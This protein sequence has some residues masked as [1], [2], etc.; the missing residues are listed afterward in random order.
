M[1][2]SR[3][4]LSW[5]GATVVLLVIGTGCGHSARHAATSIGSTT[6]RP[7]TNLP[8]TA[9]TL[10]PPTLTTPVTTGVPPTT[11][12]PTP[13][14]QATTLPP[15]TSSLPPTSPVPTSV[16]ETATWCLGRTLDAA[17]G[18]TA[19]FAGNG[20]RVVV[21]LHET[22]ASPCLV[23]ASVEVRLTNAQGATEAEALSTP[24]QSSRLTISPS[25]DA[26]LSMTWVRQGC[27]SPTV[28]A[29]AGY[30]VWSSPNGAVD[31]NIT[32]I[33]ADAVAPCHGAFGVTDLQ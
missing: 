8:P 25:T 1:R 28:D 24:A 22:A 16:R 31:V 15:V 2:P 19:P 12:R 32:G 17:A 26:S 33:A 27:F 21:T 10:P 11:V 14:T 9:G 6:T 29:A 4:R 13:P 20:A 23:P 3:P 5:I 18:P 7:T 30:L